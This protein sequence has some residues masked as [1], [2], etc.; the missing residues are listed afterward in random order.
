[1]TSNLGTRQT[2]GRL[3][4]STPERGTRSSPSERIIGA[5]AQ[6]GSSSILVG[7]GRGA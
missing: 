7:V 5:H 1:M 6:R 2:V 3:V 4:L